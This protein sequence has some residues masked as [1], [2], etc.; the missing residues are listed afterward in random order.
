LL[1]IICNPYVDSSFLQEGTVSIA[2]GLSSDTSKH[3]H[4]LLLKQNVLCMNSTSL[5]CQY[6]FPPQDTVPL[7]SQ[8]NSLSLL[9]PRRPTAS[10]GRSTRGQASRGQH[11]RGLHAG[12][13]LQTRQAGVG[14]GGFN[15]G[16]L[17]GAGRGGGGGV[18]RGGGGGVGRGGVG[19]GGGTGRGSGGGDQELRPVRAA[20][21][22]T[23]PMDNKENRGR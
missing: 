7:S 6:L 17:G 12:G 14:G 19:G 1:C 11:I 18:G 20:P 10:G 4:D 16:L 9:G 15:P 23:E 2:R 21:G 3:R 13:G 22:K 8:G 5:V